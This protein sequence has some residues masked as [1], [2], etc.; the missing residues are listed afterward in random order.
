MDKTRL[1]EKRYRDRIKEDKKE[2]RTINKK[3]EKQI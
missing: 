2:I 3:H 1:A